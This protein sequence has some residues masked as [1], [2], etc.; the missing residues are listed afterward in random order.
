LGSGSH[1]GLNRISK[2]KFKAHLDVLNQ[3]GFSSDQEFKIAFDDGYESV[4]HIAFPIMMEYGFTGIVFPVVNYIG[5]MNDWDFTFG[6]I[7][8]VKH[9]SKK[10][11]IELCKNG[12][13]IGSHGLTHTAFTAMS[14]SALQFEL[15]ESKRIL[16]DIAQIE[17][18][19]ITPPFSRWNPQIKDLIL[20]CGY[21]KIYHQQSLISHM[22]NEMIPRHSIYSI[23][24]K[25]SI[26]RKI[27][28]SKFELIKELIIH[29]CSTL[30][31]VVKEIL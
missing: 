1:I 24:G 4:Y 22:E 23:D 8:K 11:I 27:E 18:D 30:T 13:E 21:K 12:W 6:R 31:M 10:Q 28:N 17:V 14:T 15:L 3:M 7:N 16:E 26:L 5:K 29:K 2:D 20:E 25:K 9:I 19:S